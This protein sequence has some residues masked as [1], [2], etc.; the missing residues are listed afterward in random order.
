MKH[1]TFYLDFISPYAYLAFEK[2]PQALEG[3]SYSVDYRPVL[4]A[5]FLKTH[6]QLGPAE[7]PGKREW[8]YRQ[9]LWAGRTNGVDIQMPAAHPF[10]PLALLR[11]ALACGDEGSINR[12]VAETVFRHVWRGGA[13]AADAKRIEALTQRLQPG[14]DPASDEVKSELKSNTDEALARGAFGVPALAVDDKMFWGFDALPMVRACVE[15]DAWIGGDEWSAA[16]RV[17]AAVGR[18]TK[19]AA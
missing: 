14:R 1:I 3:L 8:T 12:Y 19:P 6:G 15:G 9:V 13:D 10:N 4:F 7:I 2:L 16:A 18:V 11:L 17:P 5:A